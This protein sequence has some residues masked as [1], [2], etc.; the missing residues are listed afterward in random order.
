MLLF[1]K[2]I[3]NDKY[4]LKY[5][6]LFNYSI[7]K[8]NIINNVILYNYL[9][10]N[11]TN[12]CNNKFTFTQKEQIYSHIFLKNNIKNH[13]KNKYYGFTFENIILNKYNKRLIITN[14]PSNIYNLS[15]LTNN[16]NNN[17]IILY[18]K[19]TSKYI[20]Q[21]IEEE[22]K[23]YYNDYYK[24]KYNIIYGS[25]NSN[26]YKQFLKNLKNNNEDN[27]ILIPKIKYD[28]ISCHIAL[29]IGLSLTAS[30]NMSLQLPNIISTIA[31]ALKNI[32][33]DGTLLLF[34]TIVNVN[35][36]VI[37]KILSILVHGFKNVSIINND[38]NQN[39]LIGVPE[40]YI[41][42]ESYKDNISNEIINKLLD[43]AIETLD[44]TY[45]ICDILDY[46]EDYTEKNPNHSL[47]Y[48]KTEEQK[49]RKKTKKY[50]LFSKSSSYKLSS[51]SSKTRNSSTK[52]SIK[53]SYKS[54]YKSSSKSSKPITPIYYIEDINIPELDKIMKDSNLQ[55]KVSLLMNKLE[56][57]FVGY[58]EMVNNLIVNSIA[59]DKF[60]DMY[61][62]KE[63]IL[64]KDI[65]N[66][67]KLINM[68][69]YNK[70]PY[71]KHALKVLL[72]KKNEVL[73]HFYSLD[74]PINQKLIKY[75]DR[76]SKSLIKNALDNF[77]S[78][79]S[80]KSLSSTTS[81]TLS[82]DEFNIIAEYYKRIKLAYQVKN[83]LLDTIGLERAP[84]NA[85]YNLYDFASG[86]NE[87]LNTKY[88]HLP[89]NID[90]SFVKL[91]EILSTFELIPTDAESFKVLHLCEAPGQMIMCAK[92]WAE[93]KCKKM[94][95]ENY[96][97]IANSLNPYNKST[98]N[99]FGNGNVL[100][101][102]Y[103]LIKNNYDKWLWGSDNTGDITNINNIKSI[104]NAIYDSSG[105]SN[106]SNGNLYSKKKVDLII[107][108]GN[109]I[110]ETDELLK[111]KLDLA[112]VISV[113]ACS[114]LGSD[115]CVKHSI[116]Y[117]NLNTNSIDSIDS[118]EASGMFIGYLFLYY[119]S[120]ESMSLFKPNSSN[121]D[122]SEFYVICKGF[123]GIE[124]S[125]LESLY[126]FLDKFELNSSIIEKS[127][128]PSTFLSQINNFLESMSDT[129]ILSI[130]KQNL[131]LTCFKSLGEKEDS[132]KYKNINK[133]LNCNNF[134]NE[135]S[136]DTML[137]P[138]YNEW[139]K[140]FKFQ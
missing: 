62:K 13:L 44:Y 22:Q 117:K 90:N 63:A 116:P 131:L 77:K 40:Y 129:N 84:K 133:I 130:E 54:S 115:C 26:I 61:V 12:I 128:I 60:G 126:N 120:F 47:F 48:N 17:D 75:N 31:M 35:I 119:V 93:Q 57:I 102:D 51:K 76:T 124:K 85:R 134:L 58:F 36:P 91:W 15:L 71:N 70:L 118:V 111:Q 83:N 105:G 137:K 42:C 9:Y 29:I 122:T 72:N 59:K 100:G 103:N 7:N 67:S 98:K 127:K 49:Y 107:S 86:L 10:K 4:Y 81:S 106:S 41:K 27:N 68:F 43:I 108:D 110:I 69:E 140:I 55:F 50:S 73:E 20:I 1:K 99:K 121:P 6:N 66:L 24:E 95:P 88:K 25:H 64:Q 113:I 125:Q 132:D 79:N 5:Y 19:N 139:I 37:K 53:S 87:Y 34:W 11:N 82:I 80:Y 52:S 136:I 39:L 65:T 74:T 33:K 3:N 92:Y 97:W 32:A 8:F 94:K 46:Y 135:K 21:K 30:Y 96:E 104:K 2:N 45:E 28:L 123:K 23:F 112:Q 109:M 138:K 38:I 16:K 14:K 101:D 89:I 18:Y 114:R 78:Y 56:T